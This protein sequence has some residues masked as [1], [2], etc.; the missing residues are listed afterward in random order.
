MLFECPEC[1][2]WQIE[3]LL[4]MLGNGNRYLIDLDGRSIRQ[5]VVSG[6]PSI[7]FGHDGELESSGETSRELQER[8]SAINVT[9]TAVDHWAQQ[10]YQDLQQLYDINPEY[11]Q[12]AEETVSMGNY[13]LGVNPHTGNSFSPFD[14]WHYGP[15]GQEWGNFSNRLNQ[16]LNSESWSREVFGD[17]VATAIFS[18]MQRINQMGVQLGPIGGSI[19]WTQAGPWTINFCHAGYCLKVKIKADRTF[20]F[21]D[22][23]DDA[24]NQ[25]PQLFGSGWAGGY[26]LPASDVAFDRLRNTLENR[27]IPVYGNT[28]SGWL[29]LICTYVDGVLSSCY[30]Q[31]NCD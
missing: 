19:G 4:S 20:E 29:M 3:S 16:V 17:V 12:N 10:L 15:T 26:G 21:V 23:R 2:P 31:I 11:F 1:N 13:D 14:I 25:V 18:I 9:E 5:F 7:P 27:G 8:S 28:C 30:T 6:V 24:G 22:A